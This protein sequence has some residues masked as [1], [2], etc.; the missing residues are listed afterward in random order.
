MK[1]IISLLFAVANMAFA[2]WLTKAAL[3]FLD[4][5]G[6][7]AHFLP[8]GAITNIY[9]HGLVAGISLTMFIIGLNIFLD[10]LDD[11]YKIGKH[12]RVW[13]KLYRRG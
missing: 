12:L 2:V 6:S 8:N 9:L 3:G 11:K 10:A 5:S 13:Y 4:E 7:F 1:I